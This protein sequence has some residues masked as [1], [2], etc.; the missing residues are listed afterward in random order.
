MVGEYQKIIPG[1]FRKNRK[2]GSSRPL[3]LMAIPCTLRQLFAYWNV[4][5]PQMWTRMTLMEYKY[6]LF[7][8]HTV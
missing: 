2:F 1:S 3:E 4:L 8:C 5:M 7:G 6:L